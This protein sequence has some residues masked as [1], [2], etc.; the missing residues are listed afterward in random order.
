MSM[1]SIMIMI[2]LYIFHQDYVLSV[3]SIKF[4]LS[5]VEPC[6]ALL[7]PVEPSWAQLSPVE[8]SWAQ[9]EPELSLSWAQLSSVESSLA[10]LRP[11]RA[12]LSLVVNS[13]AH[14]KPSLAI[15]GPAKP[16]WAP[17]IIKLNW[18]SLY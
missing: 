2:F 10:Q 1:V 6:W 11:S 16:R 9:V 8:P 14:F 12:Q 5:Q 17:L 4:R 15:L 18:K 3:S 7:S 13:R